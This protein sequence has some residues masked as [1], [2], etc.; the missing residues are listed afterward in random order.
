MPVTP[1]Y[2]GLYLEELPS[3]ARTITAAPTSVA[4]FVGYGHPYK[5]RQPDVAVRIFSF[6]EY[7][8]EFGGLFASGVFDP[9]L[10]HAVNQFFLNGGSV[11]WVVGVQASYR[12][13]TGSII[14]PDPPPGPTATIGGLV[15][16]GREPSDMVEMRVTIDNVSGTTGDITVT[17]GAVML[18]TYRGVSVDPA[19]ANF[20]ETV[21]GTASSP[22]SALAT[23]APTP[24]PAYPATMPAGSQPFSM[25]LPANLATTF[26]AADFGPVFAADSS[27]D[28]VDIFNILCVPGIA[29]RDVQSRALVFA[30]RK[31]AFMVVDPPPQAIADGGSPA[32]M[33]TLVGIVPKSTNGALYFPYL[34]TTNPLTGLPMALPPS[35][36]VAGRYADTDLRRG[37]WKAPAGL[38]TQIATA[39]GVAPTGQMTNQRQGVLNELGVNCLRTFPDSGTVV[40]G[41]R[42]L[43]TANDAFQQWRYVPVRRMALFVE[44][45]LLRNL[46]WAVFEPN[47]VPLWD[48]LRTTVND[49]MLGLFNQGAFQG[50]APSQ[51][52]KVVCDR[53]TT[54]QA[55]VD[56][57]IVN[58][59]VAFRPLKPAEFVIIKIAQ[60]A[61]QTP[62]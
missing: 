20:V 53:T 29:D 55:D 43:V 19:D 45:T 7:E 44:Q 34:M 39:S 17:Y 24:G 46:G 61:G 11:A 21:L 41:A 3:N 37:V 58:I 36:F 10:G 1:T 26:S 35:G 50:E 38:E 6:T 48:A 62:G 52:F 60:L 47:D 42:T 28:K 30:E 15:F 12:T 13:N 14:A 59:I 16:T 27:L 54:T 23:V 51:A 49:F 32:S 56:N 8:R 25:N 5:T 40:F 33:E 22:R 57:G 9:N 2:P 18:E 31:L 4:V